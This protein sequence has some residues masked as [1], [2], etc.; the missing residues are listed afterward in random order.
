M[1]RVAVWL[2]VGLENAGRWAGVEEWEVVSLCKGGGGWGLHGSMREVG[3]TRDGEVVGGS[4]EEGC[5]AE[6]VGRVWGRV[7]DMHI[8][9][10]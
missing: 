9:G 3:V 1:V 4:R 2:G 5:V 6:K 7:M 8:L 10:Q